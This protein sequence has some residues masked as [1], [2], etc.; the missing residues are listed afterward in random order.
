MTN[1]GKVKIITLNFKSAETIAHIDYDGI[2]FSNG[3]KIEHSHP[4][5]CCEEVYADW[6]ALKTTNVMG[7]KFREVTIY[8]IP[9]LGISLNHYLVPCYDIQNGYYS[10]DLKV[11]I[12]VR[13]TIFSF[14]IT[15]YTSEDRLEK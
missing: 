7:E 2:T 1:K 9:E 13:D 10:S 8:G 15:D 3:V 12:I 6:Q 5:E 14:D 4:Q 11:E